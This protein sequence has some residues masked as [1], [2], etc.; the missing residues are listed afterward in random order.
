M[1][2]FRQ[3]GVEE[4]VCDGALPQ[5]WWRFIWCRTLAGEEIARIET[6]DGQLTDKSPTVR[7][8]VSQDVVEQAL[9][10]HARTLP[11]ATLAFS[12]ELVG[13]SETDGGVE[14]ELLDHETGEKRTCHARYL[15]A[16]DGASSSIRRQLGIAMQGPAALSHQMS[17]YFRADL[18]PY[19]A[20]RPAD[21]YY[22]TEGDWVGVVNGRRRWLC[23]A[24][25]DAAAAERAGDLTA[26]EFVGRIRRSVGLDDLPVEV[27]NA[28]FWRIGAQAA[29]R[30]RSGRVFLAGDAAHI[31]SPT[32]GFGMNTGIQDAHNLAW[33][34]A[35]VLR[36]RA[37]PGLLD[38]YEAERKPVAESNAAWSAENARRIWGILDSVSA[39]DGDGLRAGVEDQLNHIS[40]EGRALGFQY[41]SAAVVSDG[42]PSPASSTQ[43][44]QP[45][46]SP[47]SRAPHVWLTNGR[48]RISTIDLFDLQPTLLA[49]AAGDSW[50]AGFAALAPATRSYLRL[51]TVGAGGD[52]QDPHR[53]W[54]EL[55]GLERG[56]AVLVRPD[57]HVAWRSPTEV[58][59]PGAAL[60][61]VLR[62]VLALDPAALA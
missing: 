26:E 35:A 54:R 52:L 16:A 19:T 48:G 28:T 2:L 3:W 53:D 5:E 41:A 11:L 34:L 45:T 62:Q 58:A 57:G 7:R 31:M 50:R 14:A 37:G 59:D 43:T 55:Y 24:R 8:I 60:T 40:S 1:E 56:G 9:Y 22:C 49:D 23:I 36:G 46:A 30:F 61:A 27:I 39:A 15:V 38:T 47:G 42:L 51:L 29:A 25:L 4:A 17:I 32:G 6:G 33:K 44:Y 10:R 20:W 18:T 12:T 21:I 13:F